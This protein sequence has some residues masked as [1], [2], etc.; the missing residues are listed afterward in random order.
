MYV[1]HS[2]KHQPENKSVVRISDKIFNN[3][4]RPYVRTR[5]QNGAAVPKE[6]TLKMALSSYFYI[7]LELGG[8]LL[9]ALSFSSFRDSCRPS[10][11]FP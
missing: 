2:R 1:V 8:S 5:F 9:I 3:A 10:D 6:H 4:A 7:K 11:M